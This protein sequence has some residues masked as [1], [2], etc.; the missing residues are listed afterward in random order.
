[1]PGPDFSS[2]FVSFL[3]YKSCKHLDN[4]HTVFGKLVGGAEVLKAIEQVPTDSK[5]RPEV[6]KE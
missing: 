2:A 4:K 3:T 1:M 5:D 6:R